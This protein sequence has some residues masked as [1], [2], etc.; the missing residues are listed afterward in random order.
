MSLKHAI[1][2]MLDLEKGTGYDIVKRFNESIGHFWS[3]S[4]QQVYKELHKLHEDGLVEFDAV[5]QQGKPDKKVYSLTASGLND[6]KEWVAKPAR[7]FKIKEPLLIKLF[8]GRRGS[9]AD[10]IQ[11]LDRHEILH[12][13]TAEQYQRLENQML[14][15]APAQ[16]KK[17]LLPYMTLRLGVHFENAWKNWLAEVREVLDKELD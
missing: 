9:K 7:Q 1:L 17:Y 15:L 4:H 6:L 11:E 3:S 13:Q 12:R 16:R 14:Q 8:A 2:A 5:Q 10:L